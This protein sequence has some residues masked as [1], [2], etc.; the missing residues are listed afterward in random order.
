M[1]KNTAPGLIDINNM[2]FWTLLYRVVAVVLVIV[3]LPIRDTLPLWMIESFHRIAYPLLI[4]NIALL[5]FHKRTSAFLLRHPGALFA[6]LFIAIAIIQIGGGWRSS[7]FGYTFS[8]IILFT[9]FKGKRWTYIS[10]VALSVAALIKDPSGDLPSMK[11]FF[12]S[13]LDMRMGAALIYVTAGL[14]LGYFSTL[15]QRLEILSRSKIEET[16][17]LTALEE[18]NRLALE[19]HDGAKQ[20]V[21]AMLFKTNPLMKKIKTSRDEIADELRWLW[22]GMNYLHSDLN[23]V[24]DTLKIQDN[25]D[26]AAF[27]I[28]AIIKEEVRIAEVITG[29]SWN[30]RSDSHN[31]FFPLKYKLPL[32]R[33]LSESLMNAWK[34]SGETIGNIYLKFMDNPVSLVVS[35]EGKG[36]VFKDIERSETTGLNSLKHRAKELN[37]DLSIETAPDKGCKVVL[38]LPLRIGSKKLP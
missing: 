24:M 8:T 12:V 29:F 10:T 35:D 37:G 31:I 25:T 34:H 13:N 14:I 33:F 18:K 20:M 36:F 9:I 17:K 1:N 28:L 26:K 5:V 2:F 23:Q 38:T 32:R 3:T 15:L 30:I 6:D 16:R 22:R 4:Y 21:N 27:N 7:Y 11:V 19:L